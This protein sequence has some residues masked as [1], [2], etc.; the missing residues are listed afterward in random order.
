LQVVVFTHD[1]RLV[2]SL[3]RLQLPATTLEICRNARSTLVVQE[4]SSPVQRYLGDA[5]SVLKAEGLGDELPFRVVPGFCRLALEAA[6]QERIYRVRLARGESFEDLDAEMQD[7]RLLELL[8]FALLDDRQ[9]AGAIPDFLKANQGKRE[10]SALFDSKEGAHGRF[11]GTWRDL[12]ELV[13]STGFL[14]QRL[15]GA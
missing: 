4:I 10:C 14:C 5:R 7:C 2:S 15:L 3:R 6:C 13:L 1:T 9:R 8:A 11:Q 12:D